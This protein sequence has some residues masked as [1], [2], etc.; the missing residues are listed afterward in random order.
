MKD[1]LALHRAWIMK[2]G[3]LRWMHDQAHRHYK[4]IN[5]NF[6][7]ASIVLSTISGVGGFGS[8]T[9][10]HGPTA[11]IV[12]YSIATLNIANGLLTS[13]Q[14]F[15]CAAEKSEVH[16][17]VGR[18]YATFVRNHTMLQHM[19]GTD[20]TL[21]DAAREAKLREVMV[22]LRSE[23]ERIH[24]ISPTVP[25]KVVMQFKRK[26]PNCKHPPE[27]ANGLT[28]LEHGTSQ[29]DAPENSGASYIW[30][31]VRMS[32]GSR[33]NDGEAAVRFAL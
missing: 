14:K 31:R 28:D 10:P 33:F 30:P 9:I 17:N 15:V 25:H 32:L 16:G 7:Y 2:A 19:L 6:C 8:Q 11:Q 4:K 23:Y 21:D 12:L 27:I 24:A 13:F 3:G 29:E 22:D 20:T 1:H 18:Q 5:N 26:F